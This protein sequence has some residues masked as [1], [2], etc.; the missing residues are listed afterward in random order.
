[1]GIADAWFFDSR[2]AIVTASESGIGK[3]TAAALA[4]AGMDIGVTW[5]SDAQGAEATAKEVRSNGRDD[6]R[7]A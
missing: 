6:W 1:L 5:H 2:Y 4:E 7:K 3:A